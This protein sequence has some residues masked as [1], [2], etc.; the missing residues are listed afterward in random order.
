MSEREAC[1]RGYTI[2]SFSVA[3]GIPS[4][5]IV[6]SLIDKQE[7]YTAPK[8]KCTNEQN[9]RKVRILKFYRSL[10]KKVMECWG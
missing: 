1:E 9:A 8:Y 7:H 5:Y 10:P 6:L 2:L 3:A 4:V